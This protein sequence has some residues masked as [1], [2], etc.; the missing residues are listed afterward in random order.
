MNERK[1]KTISRLN[2][3]STR[4][5]LFNFLYNP[6]KR[7]FCGKHEYVFYRNIFGDEINLCDGY[8]SIWVCKKCGKVILRDELVRDENDNVISPKWVQDMVNELALLNH[9]VHE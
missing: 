1:D 3:I 5:P 6:K 9:N 2:I 4:D 7:L 8:R